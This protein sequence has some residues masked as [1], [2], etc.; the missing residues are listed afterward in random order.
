[1]L[2]VVFDNG[3]RAVVWYN[4]LF[5]QLDEPFDI[6]PDVIIPTGAYHFD[7]WLF[8]YTGD[9][10]RRF[11]QRFSYS[12]QTFYDGTRTDIEATAGLR[13]TSQIAAEL[14]YRRNDVDL[15]WGAFV[16]NLGIL[17]FDVALS[18]RLTV[19][20]LSQYN[21]YTRQLTTSARLNFIFR[22][23]SDLYV[24]YDDL[25]REPAAGVPEIRNRQLVLKLT[26][27]LSR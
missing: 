22:P 2:G 5:E 4:R 13:A 25:W 10:S 20:T 8:S 15:P 17:R 16:V 3:A 18:P 19:R 1:M 23:G 12:P 26:Y 6:R 24:V 21:S 14:E 9:P 11:Y 7:E 27:L